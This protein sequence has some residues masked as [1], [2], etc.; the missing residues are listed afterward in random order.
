MSTVPVLA[1]EMPVPDPVP[2]DEIDTLEYEVLYALAQ[3]PKSGNS[4]V[5]PVSDIDTDPLGGTADSAGPVAFGLG[6]VE[7]ELLHAAASK[8][9][10]IRAAAV[11]A[12]RIL[13]TGE[14][15]FTSAR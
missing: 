5:L 6:G 8:A 4:S 12:R 14:Y 2:A 10:G 13:A 9:I 1:S 15:S 11:Q 7:L 3:A